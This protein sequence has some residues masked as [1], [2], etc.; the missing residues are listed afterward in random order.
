MGAGWIGGLGAGWFDPTGAGWFDP[1][2]GGGRRASPCGRI[3]PLADLRP[4]PM[5]VGAAFPRD[6][7]RWDPDLFALEILPEFL[8]VDAGA[9]G[10]SGQ[11]SPTPFR[12]SI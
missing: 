6:D 3:E 12:P 11:Q 4:V 9:G 10:N 5:Y 2:R 8:A 7:R 1:G